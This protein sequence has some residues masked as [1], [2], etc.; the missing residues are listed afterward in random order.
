VLHA[1]G[2]CLAVSVVY[3]A[4]ARDITIKALE[5]EVTGALDIRGFLGLSDDVRP[6]Y[7][8]ITVC[9]R[10]DTDASADALQ[11][12]WQHAQRISPVLDVVRNPVPISLVLE[13]R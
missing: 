7:Q 2:A 6:G 11:E 8:N 3:H 12:L 4:A 9:C 13:K 10:V 5:L 1:I